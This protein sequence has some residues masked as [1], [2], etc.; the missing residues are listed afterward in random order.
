MKFVCVLVVLVVFM[1]TS[2]VMGM[3]IKNFSKWRGRLNAITDLFEEK[4]DEDRYCLI[5]KIDNLREKIKNHMNDERSGISL[6]SALLNF[7]EWGKNF[8]RPCSL[9]NT[10]FDWSSTPSMNNQLAGQ[11][12]GIE[13]DFAGWRE[14]L[15]KV[16]KDLEK[17]VD[18]DRKAFIQ[19]MDKLREK[20]SQITDERSAISMESDLINFAEL[21]W[22]NNVERQIPCKFND[23]NNLDCL[24]IPSFRN[25]WGLSRQ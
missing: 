21:Q 7:D 14:R 13:L 20:I 6:E 18:E 25:Q 17:K 16:A 11:A 22:G 5:L 3:N 19:K 10:D 4:V 24:S 23:H 9:R 15:M 2:Q 8:E 12:M 1:A